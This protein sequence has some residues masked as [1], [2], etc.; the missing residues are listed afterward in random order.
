VDE[1]IAD[2][3]VGIVC[4]GDEDLVRALDAAREIDRAACRRWVEQ[5]FSVE[6]MATGYERLYRRLVEARKFGSP[7]VRTLHPVPAMAGD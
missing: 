4:D 1:V 5:R 7:R 6:R 2:G 3:R